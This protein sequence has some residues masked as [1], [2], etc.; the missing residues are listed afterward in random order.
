MKSIPQ[1]RPTDNSAHLIEE[2]LHRSLV[3]NDFN[4]VMQPIVRLDGED[5]CLEEN[6]WYAD[7]ALCWVLFQRVFLYPLQ[8]K[9]AISLRSETGLLRMHAVRYR[10]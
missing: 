7:K 6:V 8:K 3:C 5:N 1:I 2:E 10:R 4:L 9:T